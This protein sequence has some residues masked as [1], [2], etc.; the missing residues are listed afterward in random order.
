M[1]EMAPKFSLRERELMYKKT[2]TRI[3]GKK[4]TKRVIEWSRSISFVS[5]IYLKKGLVFIIFIFSIRKRFHALLFRERFPNY[6]LQITTHSNSVI[7][8]TA[9]ILLFTSPLLGKPAPFFFYF[10]L[11][12][13]KGLD[14]SLD[15]VFKLNAGHIFIEHFHF[16]LFA[17]LHITKCSKLKKL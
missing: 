13:C 4:I 3:S 15:S 9:Q 7:D 1:C 10:L 11:H 14:Y 8:C 17:F 6:T 12:V 2:M 16:T 5:F